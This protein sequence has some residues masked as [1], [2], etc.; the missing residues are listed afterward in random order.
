MSDFWQDARLIWFAAV[1]R[2]TSFIGWS[3]VVAVFV[4]LIV[5]L[6]LPVSS[7]KVILFDMCILAV[8]MSFVGWC[9]FFGNALRQYAPANGHLVPRVR[10]N[11]LRTVVLVWALS[12]MVPSAIFG[13]A[14]GSILWAGICFL[15][16]GS[17]F[18]FLG[19]RIARRTKI[20]PISLF[21]VLLRILLPSDFDAILAR[22]PVL[23]LTLAVALL[24]VGGYFALRATF[25]LDCERNWRIQAALENR[26]VSGTDFISDSANRGLYGAVLRRDCAKRSR[27]G[28]LLLH[29]LGPTRHWIATMVPLAVLLVVAVAVKLANFKLDNVHNQTLW[30]NAGWFLI[31]PFMLSRMFFARRLAETA[32]E[33]GLFRLSPLAPSQQQFNRMLATILLRKSAFDWAMATATL[34]IVT[35]LSGSTFSNPAITFFVCCTALPLIASPLRDYARQNAPSCTLQQTAASALAMVAFVSAPFMTLIGPLDP[36]WPLIAAVSGALAL[37]IVFTRRRSMLRAPAAFPAER[38]P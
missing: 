14:S 33:Q 11:T 37:F 7:Y 13:L 15:T 21:L 27:H 3:T 24:L 10:K 35:T 36:W 4:A 9:M 22:A 38:M 20:W 23:A 25:S 2:D 29:V 32:P 30:E 31:W 12:T 5:T 17:M 19:L 8:C 26:A 28:A 18:L 16:L 6:L 1:R 34:I